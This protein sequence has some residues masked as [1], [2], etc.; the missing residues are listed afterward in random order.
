MPGWGDVHELFTVEAEEDLRTLG[1]AVPR[2]AA[3]RGD[4]LL[5]VA[6]IRPSDDGDRLQPL[7]ELLA[8]ALPLDADRLAFCA[9]GRAWSFDDPVPP[10]VPGGPDLRQRVLATTRAD[11]HR[12]RPRTTTTVRPFDLVD[13][14]IRWEDEFDPG[15]GEGWIAE[16]LVAALRGR[17]RLAGPSEEIRRQ[18]ERCIELGHRIGFAPETAA[19]LWLPSD[20]TTA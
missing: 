16:V 5:F 9:S 18:A 17:R 6:D 11:G 1:E 12:K 15:P 7:V 8:L 2:L 14:G 19:A 10:V 20:R 13:G 3:F 4:T